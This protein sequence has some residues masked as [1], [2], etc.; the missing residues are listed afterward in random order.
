MIDLEQ[1]KMALEKTHTFSKTVKIFHG[2]YAQSYCPQSKRC[3][4]GGGGKGDGWREP[5]SH[6]NC[7]VPVSEHREGGMLGKRHD[8][9]KNYIYYVTFL[10][11]WT[12]RYCMFYS[13]GKKASSQ[14]LHVGLLLA[15]VE[16]CVKTKAKNKQNKT[17][18]TPWSVGNCYPFIAESKS[19]KQFKT[20][21]QKVIQKKKNWSECQEWVFLRFCPK[22]H[23]LS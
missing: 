12:L 5:S 7:R 19:C 20:V 22:F 10:C 23:W 11:H 14:F 3:T 21:W 13:P 8:F 9:S 4:V 15:R 2:T 16:P 18:Q 1:I 6:M 17:K